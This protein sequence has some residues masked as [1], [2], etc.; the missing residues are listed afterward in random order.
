VKS[1]RDHENA[2]PGDAWKRWY[3]NRVRE[4]VPQRREACRQVADGDVFPAAVA[5]MDQA[6]AEQEQL[7]KQSR[8]RRRPKDCHRPKEL[9]MTMRGYT[10]LE[11][12]MDPLDVDVVLGSS[13]V[14]RSRA[15][16]LVMYV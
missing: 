7:V 15:G 16:D 1:V 4:R 5:A 14:E 3:W 10:A 2:H 9:G 6:L 8:D 12:G 11:T 13:G